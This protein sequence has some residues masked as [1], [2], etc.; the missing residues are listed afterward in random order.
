MAKI[1][2][3]IKLTNCRV[4]KAIL[5]VKTAFVARAYYFKIFIFTISI[6]VSLTA[7]I[8]NL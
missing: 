6:R 8:S 2:F 3:S 5:G 7:T 4:G 1:A